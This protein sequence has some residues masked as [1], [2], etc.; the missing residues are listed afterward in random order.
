MIIFELFSNLI[1]IWKNLSPNLN[2]GFIEPHCIKDEAWNM[3]Y[4][5]TVTL[6]QNF[7]QK[8]KV[9]GPLMTFDRTPFGDRCNCTKDHCVQVPENTST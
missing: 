3:C 7:N 6:F 1:P 4:V 2:K 8:V 9:N 5:D